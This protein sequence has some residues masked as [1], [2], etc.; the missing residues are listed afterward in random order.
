LATINLPRY[1]F[2]LKLRID[3]TDR[4]T[5]KA[6]LIKTIKMQDLEKQWVIIPLD[7]EIYVDVIEGIAFYKDLHFYIERDE[8]ITLN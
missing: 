1:D 2:P 3:S 6:L 5:M 7:T 8:Y 4:V